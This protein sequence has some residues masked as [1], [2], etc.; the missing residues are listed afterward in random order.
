MKALVLDKIGHIEYKDV[1]DPKR[2]AGSSLIKVKAS[3]ICGSDI[4]RVYKTGAHILPIIPGHEFSGEVI[5]TDAGS[6]YKPGDRVG[7]FPLIPCMKCVQCQKKNYEM[8]RDYSYL[9]SRCD[10]G[11]AEYV[12]VPEWNLIKLPDHV[13]FEAAAMLE[14]LSVAAHAVR[15]ATEG[16][17]KNEEIFVYGQGT[18]GLFVDMILSALGYKNIT[19]A[20]NKDHQKTTAVKLGIKPERIID[21][22]QERA[23]DRIG[24]IT[25][26][27]G[28]FIS[29]DC[30]G[31][32]DVVSDIIRMTAPGGRVMLVG[33]PAS[34]MGL[35][36]DV[37]WKILRNQ[38]TLFGTWNSS[39]TKDED[40]DWHFVLELMGK[41]LIDPVK[42]I[43]HRFSL[44]DITGGFEIMRDKKEDYIKVM[45]II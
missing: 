25:C 15:K 24:K 8:C 9:G 29:F 23:V 17:D 4:P 22:R 21:S 14:P 20:L 6:A 34:D 38:L 40:D 2:E 35:S 3:G 32:Q 1:A 18:I 19:V 5:K 44:E 12:S 33:N 11:F 13:S 37:Y 16:V 45:G 28:S 26:D 41:G 42:M 43:T 27:I 30:I 39:F 7:I 36:K 31:K 10:G